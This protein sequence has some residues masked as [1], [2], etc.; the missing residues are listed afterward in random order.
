MLKAGE[1][2]MRLFHSR[3]IAHVLHLK[4]RSYA[5]HK[6]LNEYY[7]GIIP[8]VDSFAE[9]YIG[10]SG[11]I[12]EYPAKFSMATDAISHLD[13]LY[14]YVTEAR[15]DCEETHLQNI[16]DEVL[17]LIDSTRYKLRFSSRDHLC[18]PTT[19]LLTTSGVVTPIAVTGATT[20]SSRKRIVA[21]S[22]PSE[23]SGP[24]KT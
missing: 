17:T 8:L 19:S 15:A 2:I 11:L 4:T 7:D 12:D 18:Q 20:I 3:T 5:A 23:T 14:E 22:S 13:D 6:A 16:L 1:L 10:C 9:A 24:R 21:T